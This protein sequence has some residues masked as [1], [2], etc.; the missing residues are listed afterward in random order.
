V[1]GEVIT[2]Q[3]RI[4]FE[5]VPNPGN[6]DRVVYLYI[7][8]NRRI[9]IWEQHNGDFSM[10]EASAGLPLSRSQRPGDFKHGGDIPLL[11]AQLRAIEILGGET[12]TTVV[13][14]KDV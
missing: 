9:E 7:K 6:A 1:E 2:S 14:G 3:A 11:T 12:I 4:I 13:G 10:Y 5:V 8:G